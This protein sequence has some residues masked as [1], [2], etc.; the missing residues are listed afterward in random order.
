[1]DIVPYL[2][3]YAAGIKYKR[4][5]V[6][7]KNPNKSSL[8]SNI[9]LDTL[10]EKNFNNFNSSCFIIVTLQ[11]LRYTRFVGDTRKIRE[12]ERELRKE[13]SRFLQTY[14]S[15]KGAIPDCQYSEFDSVSKKFG[16]E[17]D[18]EMKTPQPS[19]DPIVTRMLII[20]S[21]LINKEY[22]ASTIPLKGIHLF[23]YIAESQ[24]R[25]I[26][27]IPFE[28]SFE[29]DGETRSYSLY[30][31]IIYSG[32]HYAC[33]VLERRSNVWILYDSLN[34]DD[35]PIFEDKPEIPFR[36]LKNKYYVTSTFYEL[37]V[38]NIES[39]TYEATI[40]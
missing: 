29:I 30:G 39:I 31:I 36:Y 32:S 21:R 24:I 38:P 7:I 5:I 22:T 37:Q 25:E 28:L 27:D 8:L 1:M 11:I 4:K 2:K 16:F 14:L 26:D 23:Y 34:H 33:F 40:G 17:L 18:G 6:I 19:G 10:K 3:L 13:D 35:I 20:I 9:R 15:Q 12:L